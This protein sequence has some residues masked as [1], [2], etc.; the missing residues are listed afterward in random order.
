MPKVLALTAN[1][2][3]ESWLRLDKEIGEIKW[4]LRETGSL[5]WRIELEPAVEAQRLLQ[6]LQ[7]SDADILHFSGHGSS[8]GIF[9]EDSS[10]TRKVVSGKTLESIFHTL[11]S[12]IRLVVLNSC[13]SAE[14]AKVIANE[15]DCVVGMK[16]DVSDQAAIAFSVG[17]YEALAFGRDVDSA[18]KLGCHQ[19]EILGFPGEDVPQLLS[20]REKPS[21]I[22]FSSRP[23]LWAEFVLNAKGEPIQRKGHYDMRVFLRNVPE[24]VV[25]VLYQLDESYDVEDRFTEIRVGDSENFEDEIT[26]YADFEIRVVVWTRSGGQGLRTRLVTAL[27]RTYGQSEHPSIRKAITRLVEER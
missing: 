8:T 4:R 5:N 6:I 15:I 26:S 25:S 10:D 20:L 23:E 7:H 1:P 24:D 12:N 2:Q 14:Q 9:L 27:E 3:A 17:F 11:K 13:Y 21:K 18:F 19:V 22:F 16:S